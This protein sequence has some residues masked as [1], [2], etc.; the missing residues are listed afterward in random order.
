MAHGRMHAHCPPGSW[1]LVGA[2][3]QRVQSPVGQTEEPEEGDI[4]ADPI[5]QEGASVRC[6]CLDV[7]NAHN[8]KRVLT[9]RNDAGSEV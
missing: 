4:P 7:Y 6:F 3:R 8:I 5:A 2:A 9:I 1:E